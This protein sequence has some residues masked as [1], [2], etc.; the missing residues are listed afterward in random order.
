MR[1]RTFLVTGCLLLFVAAVSL[2]R[3]EDAPKADAVKKEA[4]KA[5]AAQPAGAPSAPAAAPAKKSTPVALTMEAI[6]ELEDRKLALDAREKALEERARDLELQEKLLREKLKKMED[7]N[8]KMAERLD[9][10]QKDHGSRIGKLVAVVEGMK[11]DAAAQYVEALDPELAVEI[12]AR[13]KEL[14]AS[15]ILNLV[16]KKK[17]ARLTELYTGYRQSI[18]EPPAPQPAAKPQSAKEEAPTTKPM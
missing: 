11:P 6:Q 7:L 2:V 13:I 17:G 18:E 3:A 4:E 1:S 12:L 14:K 16:D 9:S 15:K 10:Y 5:A 8:K